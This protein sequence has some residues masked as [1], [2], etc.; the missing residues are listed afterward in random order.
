MTDHAQNRTRPVGDRALLIELADNRLVHAAAALVRARYGE[1]L[2]EV[3]PGHQTLLVVGRDGPVRIDLEGLAAAD[4]A[5]RAPVQ[6]A[7]RYDGADLEAVAA[8]LGLSV[9]A[10]VAQHAGAQYTVAFMG[11]APGFPYL[12]CEPSSPLLELPRRATPR[13]RVPAGSV[14]VAA[15]YCGIYPQASPGGWNLLGHTEL[16]LFDPQRD[17]PALLEPGMSV[18]FAPVRA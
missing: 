10:V 11:F 8:Q 2:A 9:E 16:R 18:R 3:V 17:P 1:A 15:G 5:P 13:T 4:P 6:I 7:V 12:I 14:A